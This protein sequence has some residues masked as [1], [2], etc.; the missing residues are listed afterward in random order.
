[1]LQ[2]HMKAPN[3]SSMLTSDEITG[4]TQEYGELAIDSFLDDGLL[5]DVPMVGSVVKAFSFANTL[6]KAIFT[7]KV[8]AF[9]FEA[10]TT[11]RDERQ[12]FVDQIDGSQKFQRRVGDAIFEILERVDSEG[13]PAIVG[14]LFSAAV[15]GDLDYETFL[16]LAY[17]VDSQ[18]Y[19][20]L[21]GLQKHSV[22]GTLDNLAPSDT[23][24]TSGLLN[25]DL[26]G[27]F[28]AVLNDQP[29][30]SLRLSELGNQLLAYGMPP[31]TEA[32]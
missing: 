16:R 30:P 7:R 13:K 28:S 8:Y 31:D 32:A 9:L 22:D 6:S 4:L 10:V 14:R 18:F 17:I 27:G 25:D 5:K 21:I 12:R 1:M 19:Y 24:Y 29:K 3:L 11:T 2:K 26:A 15:R 23:L 20:D